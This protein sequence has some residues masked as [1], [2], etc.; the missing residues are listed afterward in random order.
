MTAP[1][2]ARLD[3][4]TDAALPTAAELRAE[5]V[6]EYA[7][8]IAAGLPL[9]PGQRLTRAAR[10]E[11]ADADYAADGT[12]LTPEG[13]AEVAKAAPRRKAGRPP[14]DDGRK[15]IAKALNRDRRELLARLARRHSGGPIPV[16]AWVGDHRADDWRTLVRSTARPA[17]R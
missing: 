3:L 7:A 6:A 10:R 9:H 13:E 2:R 16:P 5:R 4:D 8:R 15:P 12:P 17:S 11:L 14:L 1:A